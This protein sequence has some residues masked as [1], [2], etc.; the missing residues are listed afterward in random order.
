M[1]EF[2]YN[3]IE[4]FASTDTEISVV[5]MTASVLHCL[6][7]DNGDEISHETEQEKEED[8]MVKSNTCED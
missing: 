2:Y 8:A 3:L 4:I 1:A 7:F 6:V 5:Q